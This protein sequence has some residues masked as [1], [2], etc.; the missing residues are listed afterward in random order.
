MCLRITQIRECNKG[1]NELAKKSLDLPFTGNI[2]SF[3]WVDTILG[4]TM[5]HPTITTYP[6]MI[7]LYNNE[8]ENIKGEGILL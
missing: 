4:G 2:G 3:F 6:S 8:V 1:K 7:I 5:H